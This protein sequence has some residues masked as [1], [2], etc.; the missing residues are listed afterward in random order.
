MSEAV[1]GPGADPVILGRVSGLF[2]VR[3]WVKVFSYTDPR[4]AIVDYGPWW[5]KAADGWRAMPM[6]E[7]RRHGKN[8]IA[9]L[10]GITDR[11]QAAE[12]L[13]CEIGVAAEALPAPEEGTFY[14]RDLEGLAVV[15]RD[16]KSLGNV[17]YVMET[18]T[19]DVLVTGGD[20]ERLIPFVM[21][22]VILEV[23]L[24]AGV[25]HVDWEWD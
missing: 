16:G 9:R 15:H 6:A 18:G 22:D 14:W 25:I 12:W 3:G 23:D 7:G 21:D 10:E 13:D 8:V 17:A 11:D 24:D 4:E 2:G 1:R 19:H 5:L 20:V